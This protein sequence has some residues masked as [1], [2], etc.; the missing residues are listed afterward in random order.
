MK[1]SE[2]APLRWGSSCIADASMLMSGWAAMSAVRTSVSLV[3]V[4]FVPRGSSPE[5]TERA[6]RRRA[7]SGAFV[8]LPL[9]PRARWPVAV[10][11]KVGWAFSQTLAPVVE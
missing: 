6:A 2:K 5:S 7:S 1:T 9:C 11:R 3:M 10:E 4:T 8:M